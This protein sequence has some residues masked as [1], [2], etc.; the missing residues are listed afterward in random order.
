MIRLACRIPFPLLQNNNPVGLDIFKHFVPAAGPGYF[1]PLNSR[2]VAEPEVQP[3]IVLRHVAASA[4]DFIHLPGARRYYRYPRADSIAVR[5]CANGLDEEPVL[6]LSKIL[7][8]AQRIVHV[9]DYDF[10]APII[11]NVAGSQSPRTPGFKNPRARLARNVQEIPVSRVPVH[12]P[13]LLVTAVRGHGINFRIDVSVCYEDVLS[14]V[15][16]EIQETDAPA[17]EP[18]RAAQARLVSHVGKGPVPVITIEVRDVALEIRLYNIDEAVMIIVRR[19]N[20]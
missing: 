3:Q 20:S 14:A 17:Q 16:V 10:Q 2:G 15:I 8:Q 1:N 5:L 11:V 13:L 6:L 12:Q 19:C 4:A 9:V 18:G 7:Q